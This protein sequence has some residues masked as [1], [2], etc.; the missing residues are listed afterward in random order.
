VD[1]E[2]VVGFFG[3]A[4]AVVAADPD[5]DATRINSLVQGVAQDTR[6]LPWLCNAGVTFRG[7]I[8]KTPFAVGVSLDKNGL[9]PSARARVAENSSGVQFNLTTNGKKVGYQFS[10]PIVGTPFRGSVSTGNNQMTLG[11]S[12]NLPFGGN[13]LNAGAS[14][15]FGYLGDAHCRN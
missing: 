3:E 1:D 11:A 14:L 6:S 13:T 7:Q 5:P 12:R 10:A 15:T 2:G 9:Q 8:P 4:D